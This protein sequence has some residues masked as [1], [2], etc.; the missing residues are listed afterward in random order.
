MQLYNEKKKDFSC[1]NGKIEV[2]MHKKVRPGLKSKCYFL[3]LEKIFSLDW[4]SYLIFIF[5]VALTF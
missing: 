3:L 2:R 4:Y 5:N 1:Q